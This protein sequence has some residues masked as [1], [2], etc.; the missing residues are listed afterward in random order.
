MN[1]Y[2]P[3]IS[4]AY[5]LNEQL[6][7]QVFDTLPQDGPVVLIVDRAG[8]HWPSDSQ[9]FAELQISDSFLNELGARIDDGTEP[10]ITQTG[11]CTVVAAELA[12]EKTRCGYVALILAGDRP[13]HAIASI[14]L[15]EII[16]SQVSLIAKLIEKNVLL[17]E[18]QSRY[19]PG[20][21]QYVQREA[22]LN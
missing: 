8:H 11:K 18:L 15:L 13:E 17:Y 14:D 20:T 16:I 3:L 5:L 6:A 22:A 12:T 19:A 1:I 2:D 10:V 4:P 21:P 9:A 7:R